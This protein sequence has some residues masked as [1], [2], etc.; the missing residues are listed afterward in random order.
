MCP[1][2][3]EEVFCFFFAISERDVTISSCYRGG[4]H[5][6]WD[7]PRG[8]LAEMGSGSEEGS[9]LRLIDLFITQL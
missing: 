6:R 9:Y 2:I 1:S 7:G 5:S 8:H 4:H 3:K